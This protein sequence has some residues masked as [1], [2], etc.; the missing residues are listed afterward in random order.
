MGKTPKRYYQTTV[1]EKPPGKFKHKPI[2]DEISP[3]KNENKISVKK[4]KKNKVPKVEPGPNNIEVIE[5]NDQRTHRPKRKKLQRKLEEIPIDPEALRRHSRGDGINLAG[6]KTR[7]HQISQKRKEINIEFAAEQAA[8]AEVLLDEEEGYIE[9]DDDET[10]SEIKQAEIVQNV[11]I[12]TAAKHFNLQLDFGPYRMRYTKNGS[13][14]LL[15]GRKG[16]VAAFNWIRKSLLCEMNVMESVHDVTWLMNQT[17]FAVAQKNWVHV[18]DNKGTEIHCI[19]GMNRV[20]KMEYLPYHFLLN[21]ANE[22]GFLSWMDV[23][24]G[25]TVASYNSRMGKISLM[26]QNPWNAV[27]CVGNSKGV[28][29]MWAPSVREPLAKMLCHSMPLTA[30]A[31][32]PQGAQLATAGLDRTIKIWDIRQLEGP[33]VT[34]KLQ[35]A[36]SGIDISQRGLMAISMGNIC[37]IYKKPNIL[38]REH[39]PY[40]RQR[41][42][43]TISNFR[44]CPYE[45]ILG[46]STSNGFTSI[47]VPG[48][49]EPNFDTMEAN[50][51]QTLSQRRE[52]EIHTLLEKIP[53]E[54][55]SLNPTQ[56]GEVDVPTMKDRLETKAKALTM[57]VPKI[58]FE[59][60]VKN[61]MSKAKRFKNKQIVKETLRNEAIQ[62]IKNVKESLKSVESIETPD[63]IPLES[64]NVLDRFRDKKKLKKH[65]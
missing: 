9:A 10:T 43:T 22:E 16:H 59:P 37:E 41:T 12:T 30:I 64:K 1:D 57:K 49:G 29:S 35:T 60:R 40:L 44:F 53:S 23:S 14:L 38:Q 33:M 2:P 17:M 18:Y 51:F 5:V 39:R 52:E 58:D 19:K 11:D 36:A 55:I 8:R 56:I 4:E 45:D 32:D 24:I 28:V 50:P 6:V 46:I 42:A 54:F 31:V 25:Q 27:T 34:Y 21:A 65:K 26:C 63:F 7:F 13:Y 48:A 3:E 20:T 61:R 15:G 47:I 62:N